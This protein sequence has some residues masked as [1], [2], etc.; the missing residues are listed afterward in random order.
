MMEH[1]NPSLFTQINL[2]RIRFKI[3][4][5]YGIISLFSGCEPFADSQSFKQDEALLFK[6]SNLQSA[7]PEW[8]ATP[9]TLKVMSW[10][11]KYGALR[12][13][14]WFDCWG[15]QVYLNPDQVQSNLDQLAQFIQ[16]ANP[17]LLMVQEIE[18]NSR[19]SAYIDMINVL[20]EKTDLNYAAYFETWDSQYIPSEG[21][22]RMNLGNA[23]FSKYPITSAQR[24]KQDE[25]TDLD[26]LTHI[27]YIKRSIGRAEIELPDQSKIATFVIHTEAYDEDGTKAKQIEQIYDVLSNEDLPFILG[28]DFN[29][30]PPTALRKSGFPDERTQAI[31]SDE[32]DQPPYTPE[33]MQPFYDTFSPWITLERYGTTEEEQQKYFTHSVLGSTE[34][35]ESGEAGNWN[36]TLDY[37]FASSQL[38]WQEDAS[39]VL[40]TAGQ[41]VGGE[42]SS[43]N[44]TLEGNPIELSDHAPVFGIVELKP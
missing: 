3:A 11:I 7:D 21:V 33:V 40:Q 17:D 18:I 39:D 36:R 5:L 12:A 24:I 34:D 37:L 8:T 27:F 35:N 2:D 14:F 32:F 41:K 42:T 38:Q 13:P 44:W 20:L 43:L 28:G 4:F 1:S 31:C 16:E 29:E 9:Q 15:D 26:P 10:N 30:I 19:R 6:A 22:G 25:R 23:I